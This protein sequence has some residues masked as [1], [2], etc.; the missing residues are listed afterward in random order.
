MDLP[1]ELAGVL[2][3]RHLGLEEVCL[4]GEIGHFA[5]PGEGVLATELLGHMQSVKTAIGDVLDILAEETGIESKNTAGH[6]IL[7]IGDLE[8][9]GLEDHG[10]NLRLEFRGPGLRILL[11]DAVDEVDAEVQMDRLIAHDVLELLADADHLVL[12]LEG[13]EHDETAVEEDPLHDDVEAD[14]ILDE[15][16]KTLGGVGGEALLHDRG[17]EGHL[18]GILIVDGVHLVIHVED[19]TLIKGETLDDVLEGVGM[20]RLLEGLA[21]HVLTGLGIGDM[22]EDRK[23]DVVPDKA[24]SGAEEAEIPHDDLALVCRELIGLPELDI[25]LHRDLV[26]HPVVG[27]TLGVVIPSPGVL[28]GH[29]LVDINLFAVDQAFLIGIDPLGEVV[30]CGGS[31]G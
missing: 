31:I 30:E 29:E 22:L 25:A 19:L 20:D 4:L 27:A 14:E 12:A 24:L 28:Q 23:H 2:V 8:F 18:E 17:G 13:E 10:A 9:D 21:E 3:G 1:L 11:A 5:H 6:A 16:L 26:R 7:S 15:L